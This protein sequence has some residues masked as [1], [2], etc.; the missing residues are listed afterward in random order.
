MRPALQLL[1]RYAK[2]FEH[3]IVRPMTWRKWTSG[4]LARLTDREFLKLLSFDGSNDK[5]LADFQA[6]ARLRFFFHPRNQKDFFLNLLT[7]TQAEDSILSDAQDVLENRFETLGSGKMELGNKIRWQQD[8]KS[9]KEW[10]LTASS[11]LDILDIEHSSDVKV[12]WE[13][14]RFHQVWWLGKAYWLTH[15]ERYAEKFRDL[16]LD[17]IENNPPGKGVNWVVAMEAAI[18]SANWIAGFYF[19]C[20]SPSLQAE[21]W[22]KFL[23]GLYCHGCFIEGNIEYARQNGNHF[24]SDV[25][26]LIFLGIFFQHTPFGDRWLRWGVRALADEMENQVYPDGV[27]YEK[28]TS[29][30]RLVLELFYTPA[31]LCMKNGIKMPGAFMERLEKMFEFVECY[32]RPDGSIPLMGDADDGRLFRF[33]MNDEINDHRHAVSVG[34]IM[35][36]RSD[37]KQAARKFYQDALW[38]LGGEGFETYQRLKGD[39]PTIVSQS[40]PLGGFYVMKNEHVHVAIDAGDIGMRGLG[41]H[42]HNDVL[43]FELWAEGEPVIVDSGTYAYTFDAV[44]RQEL[45][46]TRA[47]NTIMVDRNE[48]ATFSGLWRIEKDLTSPHVS[49]WQTS[50]QEDILEAEHHAYQSLMLPVLVRRRFTLDKPRLNLQISDTLEGV[51]KHLAESFLHFAPGIL[52]SVEEG[53]R[54]I[55]KTKKA[56]YSITADKG[57]FS[58]SETWFSP[59]YGVRERKKTLCLTFNADVPFTITLNIQRESVQ[60]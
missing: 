32:I 10:P 27:D 23:K 11:S 17:W 7:R 38:L 25:V 4:R 39:I 49:R 16:I 14:S 57:E 58:M 24:L 51:G 55:A 44:A 36:E 9:G 35:F 56:R 13:L 52:L 31:I 54:A 28:S 45:R 53:R 37:F 20:E 15:N 46:G 26:G 18:R 6:K 41:G 8:F 29:Y 33:S 50:P 43:S 19:F 22:L 1:V 3:R 21:F 40:F 48:I 59:S 12:P 60:E 42:G 47:H 34:A 30:Q 5:F 2:A